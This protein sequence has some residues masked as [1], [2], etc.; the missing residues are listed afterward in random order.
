M[1][2]PPQDPTVKLV[3][4]F[5]LGVSVGIMVALYYIQFTSR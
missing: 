5:L 1:S 3:A 4:V 2:E